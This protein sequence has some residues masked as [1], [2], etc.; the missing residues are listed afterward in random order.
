MKGSLYTNG[1][2]T[3]RLAAAALACFSGLLL[4]AAGQLDPTFGK[5]GKVL[6]PFPVCPVFCGAT[7]NA[8]ALQSDG[9]IVV[10]GT[11]NTATGTGL[12]SVLVRYN[13]N[14]S[15]DNSFGS[16]GMTQLPSATPGEGFFAVAIQT[17]GKIV[18]A[19][20]QQQIGNIVARFN[21]NGTLDTTF[22]AAGL[23]IF[24]NHNASPRIPEGLVLQPDGKILLSYGSLTRLNTDGS[25][26]TTFGSGG[27]AA[28]VGGQSVALQSDG[29][30]LVGGG[31]T[32][33]RYS[34]DGTLDTS[35]GIAGIA[36]SPAELSVVL[37]QGNGSILAAGSLSTQPAPS[38]SP[39]TELAVLRYT[40]S[41]VPDTPFGT[42]GGAFAPPASSGSL[43]DAASVAV[44]TNGDIVAGGL[45]MVIAG[46]GR[47]SAQFELARFTGAGQI[48]PTFG[49]G[50]QVITSF[51]GANEFVTVVLLQADGKIV[52]VGN[53]SK[54]VNASTD[55]SRFALARYL[56]Q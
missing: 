3:A 35:F 41:G 48:D 45:T 31:L 10:A 13:S 11:I 29:K 1:C 2:R 54:V 24:E 34:S 30:I 15:L 37:F 55:A 23:A 42:G 16:A 47:P 56:A 8:A 17:D 43:S 5:S 25:L 46:G 51:G 40:V 44:Q 50:G 6:T 12:V 32:L 21:A 19:T 14:G 33:S 49:G 52:A 39:L 9:K 4:A 20:A 7:P 22:A 53:S 38:G 36:G 27:T 18:A 26:D 28:I